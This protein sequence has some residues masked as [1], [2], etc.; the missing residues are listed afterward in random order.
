MRFLDNIR[1]GGKVAIS[2]GVTLVLLVIAIGVA[3]FG[4]IGASENFS[5]YRELARGA[6]AANAIRGEL[7]AARISVKDFILSGDAGAADTAEGRM[8]AAG[9]A[10]SAAENLFTDP[11]IRA[12]LQAMSADI[13][14]Y[15]ETFAAILPMHARRLELVEQMDTSGNAAAS[16]MGTLLDEQAVLS[17]MRAV[18]NASAVL[19]HLLLARLWAAR[20]LVENLPAQAE[21]VATALAELDRNVEV[22]RV[23][24]YDDVGQ[25]QIDAFAAQAATFRTAFGEVVQ[26]IGARNAIVAERLDPAG[27]AL[28]DNLE[29]FSARS[30]AAQDEL[31]PRAQASIVQSE[32]VSI[33]A[34]AIA[35]IL[36]ILLSVLV[37]RGIARPIAAMTTA[38][39]R[40]ADGD[41]SVE[42]VGQERRDEVG[43]MA[44]AVQVFKDNMIRNE[45]MAAEQERERAAREE[46]ARQ[47][48]A[49]TGEF[50]RTVAAVLNAVGTATAEMQN[51]AASMSATAEE[52]NRQAGAVAAAAEEA[53]ANV[54]TVASAAEELSSS[55]EEIG[56]QVTQS[57][58]IAGQASEDAQRTNERVDGLKQSAQK[59][60]EVVS[61]IQ[62]IAEQTNL[63]ALNATIEAARAGEAGKGFAVVASEVKNL[64]TQTAK[65]TEQIGRQIG[66]IQG[67]TNEAV[68]AIQGIVGTIGEINEIATTIASAVE[69][70]GAA[71][72]EISRNV[73]EAAQGTQEV[74]A[75][76]GGVTDAAAGTGAAAEQVK[77]SAS[78]L[79]AQSE[80]LRQAVE[81]F[82]QRVRAA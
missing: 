22:L 70:Q 68:T 27:Q 69:E 23:A 41:K 7:L 16:V 55:I 5:G 57:S 78:N 29:A 72:Q 26:T 25:Q 74:S 61:L 31:G 3:L 54:Q 81:S 32:T 66:G 67:E 38:M 48:E 71:T 82:L 46:R 63:L 24:I 6:N 15:G 9:S 79:A 42:V 45:E 4:L 65:A 76:I 73:Q 39:Q 19:R 51:T 62:D 20:F 43:A 34:A 59:I 80:S 30:I 77:A 44:N 14:A 28:S 53:S 17:N 18:T 12:E 2:S 8:A 58:M 52:T 21:R 64:A 1:I 47:I 33:A 10:A 60:G 35:L 49:L 56:R 37:G 50:D 11:A 13:S 40:L 75:N 36:A